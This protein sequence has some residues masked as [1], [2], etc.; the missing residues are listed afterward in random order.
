MKLNEDIVYSAYK[1]FG[2]SFARQ[3]NQNEL[4]NK[5]TWIRLF[6]LRNKVDN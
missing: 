3:A 2:L 5:K 6:V 4:K 1:D